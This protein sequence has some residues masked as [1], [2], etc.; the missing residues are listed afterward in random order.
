MHLLW[1]L[2]LFSFSSV[3]SLILVL[4]WVYLS[5]FGS[6]GGLFQVLFLFLFWLRME[7]GFLPTCQAQATAEGTLNFCCSILLDQSS[8]SFSWEDGVV[9]MQ[10]L[11]S[12]S[13]LMSHCPDSRFSQGDFFLWYIFYWLFHWEY[14]SKW[15]VDK[16][17]DG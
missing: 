17:G 12:H 10:V 11:I 6:W 3:C 9:C 16:K 8:S 15:M 2:E 13:V 4:C 5:S 7:G 1:A 14:A